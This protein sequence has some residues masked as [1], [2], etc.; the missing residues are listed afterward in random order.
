M[1]SD[2]AVL[3]SSN[4]IV[5]SNE[6]SNKYPTCTLYIIVDGLTAAVVVTGVVSVDGERPVHGDDE[7]V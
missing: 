5:C 7:L 3:Q 1:T 6:N 4:E 2:D